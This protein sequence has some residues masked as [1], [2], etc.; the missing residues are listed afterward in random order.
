MNS[1]YIGINALKG[2]E[3]SYYQPLE[4]HIDV[5]VLIRI[6]ASLREIKGFGHGKIGIMYF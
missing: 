5:T 3:T 6:E 1:H 2:F 4:F